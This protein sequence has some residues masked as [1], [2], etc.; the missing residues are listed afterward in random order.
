MD[1]NPLFVPHEH[2]RGKEHV[3]AHVL[4]KFVVLAISYVGADAKVY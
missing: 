4:I 3:R 2:L 1:L